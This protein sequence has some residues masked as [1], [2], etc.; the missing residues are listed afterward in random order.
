M[1]LRAKDARGKGHFAR[2]GA[3]DLEF[4]RKDYD[5]VMET[6]SKDANALME[7]PLYQDIL[8]PNSSGTKQYQ[9]R[10]V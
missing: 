7:E 8:T 4:N 3:F 9:I 5:L 1:I 10:L 6:L 2:V